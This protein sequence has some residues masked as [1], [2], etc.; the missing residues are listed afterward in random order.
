VVAVVDGEATVKRLRRT[1]GGVLLEAENPAFPPLF[2]PAP[3]DADAA[4]SPPLRIA[5][6]VV[7]LF[8]K[9]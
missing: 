7:G 2:L 5:G 9:M 3:S 8:R 6:K 1:D 4:P